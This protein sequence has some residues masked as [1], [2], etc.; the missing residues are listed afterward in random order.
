M[1]YYKTVSVKLSYALKVRPSKGKKQTQIREDAGETK[2][3][4]N[5]KTNLRRLS[6]YNKLKT[7][8]LYNFHYPSSWDDQGGKFCRI[9]N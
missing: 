1:Q 6:T 9:L 4:C 7:G 8:P 2:L 3:G 5:M